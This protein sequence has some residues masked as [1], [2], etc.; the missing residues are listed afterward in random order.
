[1]SKILKTLQRLREDVEGS[2]QPSAY[3]T[4]FV[5]D[6]YVVVKNLSEGAPWIK[7]DGNWAFEGCSFAD[8]R[9]NIFV[10]RTKFLKRMTQFDKSVMDYV[11]KT[12]HDC[13]R[14]ELLSPI[15]SEQEEGLLI[16]TLSMCR[17]I[18][19]LDVV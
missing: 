3:G 12:V 7:T 8:K 18:G 9:M 11:S 19:Q 6:F 16:G 5:N 14:A 2:N 4:R 1:M 17:V 15:I 13:V 10:F